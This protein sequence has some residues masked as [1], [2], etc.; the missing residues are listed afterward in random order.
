MSLSDFARDVSTKSAKQATAMLRTRLER[1]Y[2]D[3]REAEALAEHI[4]LCGADTA[5]GDYGYRGAELAREAQ[6]IATGVAAAYTV[7]DQNALAYLP[8]VER[9]V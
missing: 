9:I 7:L 6:D 4:Q 8:A 2:K 5:Y 3:L 1:A